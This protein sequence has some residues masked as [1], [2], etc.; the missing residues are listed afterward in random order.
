MKH[1]VLLCNDVI[2]KEMAGPG[3]RYW[4][5][6]RVLAEAEL[7]VTL[8]IL[9]FVSASTW[10]PAPAQV[11]VVR[12]QSEAQ[13]RAL[14]GQAD[15]LVTQGI[16][17]STYPFLCKITAPLVLDFYI[18]FLLERLHVDTDTDAADHVFVNEGYRRALQRQLASA[19]YILCASEKQ[20]DYYVGALS[21]AGRVNPYTH[22]DDPTLRR[23]IDVVP[24]GLPELPP[25]HRHPVL[26]GVH[27]GIAASDKVVLWGGGI[28][29]WLDA[30]T[31][32]RAMSLI[33]QRRADVKL[34]FMGIKRPSPLTLKMR[35]SADVLALSDSLGLTGK[36]VLFNEWT[37][38]AE[39]EN[40]LL[41]AD[42]GVSLHTDHL[43]TRFSFRT[44]FLD[45]VWAGLPMVVTRGDVLSDLVESHGLGRA[46]EPGDVEGVAEAILQLLE[47]P[48]LRETFRP[49]FEQIA[50]R[51]R[52]EVVTRPLVEFCLAPR[53]APDKAFLRHSPSFDLRP[54][55]WW[56]L[57]GK[58]ASA[59]RVGGV[60]GLA[61]QVKEYCRWLLNRK[62]VE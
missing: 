2:G 45:Y 44:R 56:S 27:P 32:I 17:L 48:N 55:P 19:D 39:R 11:H 4:E 7:R 30:P 25:Q 33:A 54:T 40:Y 42:L 31:L 28:W 18:P 61:R 49:R 46:V 15:V 9:P 8:A 52:W 47:T 43:E 21:A 41:E 36:Y 51:Y 57:P 3:I 62:N 13:V 22:A 59:L 60:R 14:A 24:F 1:V 16:V 26:K 6:A 38:Y 35:A 37:P 20:R 29:N 23:L 12:C 53:H 34:F 50:D 5:F 58:A 10:P